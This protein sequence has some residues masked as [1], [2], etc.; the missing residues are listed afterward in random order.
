MSSI[1][2]QEYQAF[3]DYLE[4]VCGIMLGDNK[5]YLVTSRLQKLLSGNGIESFSDLLTK[6]QAG[7]RNL[8]RD[9]VNAMTTNETLW[10]RDKHPF[11][12]LRNDI[13][14]LLTNKPGKSIRIWSAACSSGQEPYTISMVAHEYGMANPGRLAG[15]VQI[16][17]TDISTHILNEA[18]NG[19]YVDSSLSR[20]ISEERRKRYFLPQDDGWQIRPE[21][22]QR[23]TFSELNLKQSYATLGK[24][25]VVFC[26]NVLIYFSSDLKR[27]IISRIART[28]NP[29]GY[30]FLGSSESITG[31]S[32]EF[33]M[34]R[35][36][37]GVHYRLK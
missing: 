32:D 7:N 33:E 5:H 25:D 35:S 20:G 37:A 9:I 34:V 27:D 17:A 30:L 19:V 28:L 15:G 10:F 12:V 8:Q 18:R 29:G 21:I 13:F 14:P 23:V 1:S 2:P 22:R 24:F 6:L 11:E 36:H 16:V 31:H 4:D 26:R 3:R